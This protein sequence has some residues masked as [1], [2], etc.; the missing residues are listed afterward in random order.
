[1]SDEEKDTKYA[2]FQYWIEERKKFNI[3]FTDKEFIK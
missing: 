2:H 3:G 1:M